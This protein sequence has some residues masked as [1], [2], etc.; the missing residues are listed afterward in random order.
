M[1]RQQLLCDLSRQFY[2]KG[3]S[4]GTGGG[5]SMV[6]SPLGAQDHI[7]VAPSGVQ[8]ERLTPGDLFTVTRQGEIVSRP[9]TGDL[10]VSECLPLF[11]HAY[12]RRGAGAVIHSH[13]MYAMLVTLRPHRFGTEYDEYSV[14]GL[15][16]IKGLRGMGCFDTLR[17]P[18]IENTPKEC[19]LAASMAEAMDAYPGVDAVLVR[20]HGLY[21]WGKDW[22]QAKTQAECLDYLFEATIRLGQMGVK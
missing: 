21:V 9:L 7:Y 4:S 17:V 19:D 6:T 8:K 1:N 15:E 2:E 22:E 20:G 11:L 13:S 18:I 10:K 16:M 14:T 12:Q 3:W 5:I